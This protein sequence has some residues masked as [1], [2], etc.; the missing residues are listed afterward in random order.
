MLSLSEALDLALERQQAGQWGE[1]EFVYER[2]LEAVPDYAEAWHRFGLLAAQTSG[3]DI[4]LERLAR[5]IALKPDVA[6]YHA[7]LGVVL[8]QAGR[9]AESAEAC[10]RALALKPNFPN[11]RVWAPPWRL[12]E[13]R[14]KQRTV[15]NALWPWPPI[16]GKPDSTSPIAAPPWEKTPRRSSCIDKFSIITRIWSK[17]TSISATRC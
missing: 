2:I 12:W 6:T 9:W 5:A 10:R 11:A 7:N 8:R 4:A 16:I 13:P 3:T 17:L 15:M 14:A 1:A